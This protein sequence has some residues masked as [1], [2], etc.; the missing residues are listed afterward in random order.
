MFIFFFLGMG[1]LADK[2]PDD[3][4][5]GKAMGVALGGLAIGVLGKLISPSFILLCFIA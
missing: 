4:E 1:M 3:A 2:Y 5:R